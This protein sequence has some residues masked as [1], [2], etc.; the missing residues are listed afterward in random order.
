MLDRFRYDDLNIK[1]VISY[2]KHMY[3]IN[4][5]KLTKIEN[6]DFKQNGF[7]YDKKYY[8]YNIFIDK[9]PLN[10]NSLIPAVFEIMSQ[11][12]DFNKSNF[13]LRLDERLAVPLKYAYVSTILKFQK[14][15]GCTF[16]FSNTKL[17]NLKNII[18]HGDN[19]NYNKLLMVIK[20]RYD[21][22]LDEEFWHIEIE[23][24]PYIDRGFKSN[25]DIITTF[26]HGKYYPKRKAFR[27][28]DFIK[29]QYPFKEYCSKQEDNSTNEI[30][31][32][33][34]TTKECHYKVW[35]IENIDIQEH[36]WCELVNVSLSEEYRKLFGEILDSSK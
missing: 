12:I 26:I 14:W 9:S 23:E 5:Y 13:Y 16:D 4:D 25:K 24:L 21:D 7:I 17:E 36:I 19:D 34:Y 35:C 33:F 28:I 29:N 6:L 2:E 27:H 1:S 30:K 15:R 10:I 11:N 8:L 20:K 32:D 18:V 3:D 22:I 31:I